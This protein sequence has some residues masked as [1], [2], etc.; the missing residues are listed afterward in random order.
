[1]NAFQR[2]LLICRL[3]F[4]VGITALLAVS[5]AEAGCDTEYDQMKEPTAAVMLVDTVLV[6][7]LAFV[8]GVGGAVVWVVSLPFTLL[9]GNTEEAGNVLVSDPFCYTFQRPLGHMEKGRPPR[10]L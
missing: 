3:V 1:M 6:R 9:A 2:R 4:A 10:Q 7:P 8:A 5:T